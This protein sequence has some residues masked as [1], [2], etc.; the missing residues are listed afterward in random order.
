M[1][2]FVVLC[3]LV[4]FS[5]FSFAGELRNQWQK[6]KDNAAKELKKQGEKS[7][8]SLVKFNKDFGPS[9]DEFEKIKAKYKGLTLDT[10]L[11]NK[12][13]HKSFHEFCKKEF[14]DEN[15]DFYFIKEQN[16]VV[17]NETTRANNM[18]KLYKDYI[19]ASGQ[20]QLNISGNIKSM[21]QAMNEKKFYVTEEKAK[22]IIKLTKEA[23]KGNMADTFFRFILVEP[24]IA[25][26]KCQEICD[27]YQREVTEKLKG[28]KQLSAQKILLDALSAIEKII[29]K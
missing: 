13:W 11:Q 27:L 10:I 29:N 2:S 1:R 18:R 21:W 25:R 9:L 22:E 23:A 20:K 4:C 7:L 12:S 16:I 26:K 17:S 5:C 28:P 8:S 15:W 14:S 19:T 3:M 24:G 6:A